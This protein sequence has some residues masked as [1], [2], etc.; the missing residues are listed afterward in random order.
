MAQFS[1]T[2]ELKSSSLPLPQVDVDEEDENEE[3]PFELPLFSELHDLFRPPQF[4][5]YP[6]FD[7]RVSQNKIISKK[8]DLPSW[9]ISCI[10]A[11]E[12]DDDVIAPFAKEVSIDEIRKSAHKL[13]STLSSSSIIE[14]GTAEEQDRDAKIPPRDLVGKWIVIRGIGLARVLGYVRVS[15]I[16]RMKQDSVHIIELGEEAHDKNPR[17]MRCV[18]R[19]RKLGYWNNG[20]RFKVV[21]EEESSEA[22]GDNKEQD[23]DEEIIDSSSS[24]NEIRVEG[25]SSMSLNLTSRLRRFT[26]LGPSST[27]WPSSASFS[28]S[29]KPATLSSLQPRARVLSA[30]SITATNSKPNE[31]RIK[32]WGSN[33][34][35]ALDIQRTGWLQLERSLAFGGARSNSNGP[36]SVARYFSLVFSVG[37]ELRLGKLMY[38]KHPNKVPKDDASHCVSLSSPDIVQFDISEPNRFIVG[39]WYLRAGDGAEAKAWVEDITRAI[40]EYSKEQATSTLDAMFAGAKAV[41]QSS[42]GGVRRASI[43]KPVQTPSVP[44]TTSIDND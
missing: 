42:R 1:K 29:S 20:L 27:E 11:E 13:L 19:R 43:M 34:L 8:F 33:A 26:T 28:L 7:L 4:I 3:P 37:D 12:E 17:R 24:L 40:S 35:I 39:K 14:A 5:S 16:D 10:D 2:L 15:K 32:S 6:Q 36:A 44:L 21:N 25:V 18:L 23:K 30:D 41:P 38:S 9:Q 31:P 22:E